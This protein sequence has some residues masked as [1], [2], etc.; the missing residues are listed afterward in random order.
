MSQQNWPLLSFETAEKEWKGNE[1]VL[2]SISSWSLGLLWKKLLLVKVTE[3]KRLPVT[4]PKRLQNSQLCGAMHF[5]GQKS[6]SSFLQESLEQSMVTLCKR[7]QQVNPVDRD[8]N[9]RNG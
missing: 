8:L 6:S 5:L 9:T 3:V 2:T 1:F 4:S 7:V